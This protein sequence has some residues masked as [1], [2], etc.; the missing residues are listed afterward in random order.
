MRWRASWTRSRPHFGGR[1]RP[2]LAGFS[3]AKGVAYRARFGAPLFGNHRADLQRVLGASGND[4]ATEETSLYALPAFAWMV[5]HLRRVLDTSGIEP[6]VIHP[7]RVYE[8]DGG[9]FRRF[10]DGAI[11]RD[12][13]RIVGGEEVRWPLVHREDL[14]TTALIN[15]RSANDARN[16]DCAYRV[17]VGLI[18]REFRQSPCCAR[19]RRAGL[20]L[21][22]AGRHHEAAFVSARCA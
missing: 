20:N 5:P 18:G 3:I 17:S 13:I 21:L 9:V 16:G 12:A 11:E 2:E 19:S 1:H 7:A 8:P 10:V 22:S 15:F 14:V 4:V 6:V